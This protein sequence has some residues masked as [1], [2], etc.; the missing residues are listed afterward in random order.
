MGNDGG[1]IPKRDDLVKVKNRT[2][3]FDQTQKE[4][5]RWKFCSLSKAGHL[6]SLRDLTDLRL[7]LNEQSGEWI[8]PISLREMGSASGRMEQRWIYLNGCGCVLTELGL[9]QVSL[10]GRSDESERNNCPVCGAGRSS[11]DPMDSLTTLNPNPEEEE[12][13]MIKLLSRRRLE[14][15]LKEIRKLEKKEKN[16]QKN[17]KRRKETSPI[18]SRDLEQIDDPTHITEPESSHKKQKTLPK[19]FQSARAGRSSTTPSNISSSS[20]SRLAQEIQKE[21]QENLVK[22]S[23]GTLKSIYG[24]RDSN[25]KQTLGQ[26]KESW[27]TRGTWTR[28]AS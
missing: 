26:Q 2:E 20:M 27:M 6:I 10:G 15:R 11:S 28:Y 4:S 25:G 3:K 22:L 19:T 8:C 24:P 21:T 9:R 17:E 13:M 23:S 12:S 5:T 7:S 18:E 1:S 16:K 14:K